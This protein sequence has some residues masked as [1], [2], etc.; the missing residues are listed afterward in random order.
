MIKYQIWKKEQMQNYSKYMKESQFLC[1]QCKYMQSL[2][3]YETLI[4]YNVKNTSV[5]TIKI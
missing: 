2:Y 3:K 1:M 4:F 5:Y